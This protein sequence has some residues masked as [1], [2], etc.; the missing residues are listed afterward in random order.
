MILALIICIPFLGGLLAWALSRV[1]ARASQAI[2]LAALVADA[3]C[4]IWLWRSQAQT[5]VQ[6]T[7]LLAQEQFAWI[8]SMGISIHLGMDGLSL[9]LVAL[10][11][12]LG[13]VSIAVPSSNVPD[14]TGFFH[15]NVLWYVS[16]MMAVFMALDL[17]LFYVA[18]ELMLVPMYFIIV[19][20]G[21]ENRIRA[22][23]KFFVFTQASSLFLLVA[24]VALYSIHGNETGVYTFDYP[25][26]LHTALSHRAGV[27]LMLAF[28]LAFAVKLGVVPFHG[29]LPDAYAEAPFA[30]S[31]LLA[32]VMAKTGAYGLIRFCLPLFPQA[33]SSFALIAMILGAIAI[34]YGALMALGQTDIKRLVAYTSVSHMGFVLLGIYVWGQMS[35][36]GVV[37]QMIS[38]GVTVAALF[39]IALALETRMGSRDIRRYGGLWRSAP[40]LGGFSVVFALALM[41]LPGLGTFAGEVLVLLDT[42]RLSIPL[43]VIPIAGTVFAV[44]YS[45]WMAQKVFMGSASAGPL[46]A[47]SKGGERAVLWVLTGLI[48]WLGL[49]PKPILDTSAM[50]VAVIK[51]SAPDANPDI[52]GSMER[53]ARILQ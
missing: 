52:S 25:A 2:S 41:G 12:F 5:L 37:L 51:N 7:A 46:C 28:F 35:L 42:F 23:V 50:A 18:W 3:G 34:V 15:F 31:V 13:I 48:L 6:S 49:F 43:A 8:P 16:A 22:A 24:I 10:T 20:W 21:H 26:L 9:L 27:W 29:W 33:S 17:F 19:L 4:L 1:H 44:V 47:D 32:G 14:R 38:H 11:L 36:Q 30:G 45:L 39:L 40:V 53:F